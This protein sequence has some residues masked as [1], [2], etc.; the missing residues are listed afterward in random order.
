MVNAKNLELISRYQLL[1]VALLGTLCLIFVT[2][3]AWSAILGGALM[4]ANF[5]LLKWLM[6]RAISGQ[7]SAALFALMLGFKLIAVLGV[8]GLLMHFSLIHPVGFTLGLSTL[9]IA[10]VLSAIHTS[11]QTD[12]ST[13]TK[14]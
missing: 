11:L 8:I 12:N 6:R 9:F 13:T 10:M 14:D 5:A 2:E 7:K 3:V 4:A 1:A